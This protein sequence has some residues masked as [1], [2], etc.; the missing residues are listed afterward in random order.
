MPCARASQGRLSRATWSTVSGATTHEHPPLMKTLYGLSWRLFHR[1]DCTGPKRGLHP[2]AV[3]KHRTLP[4]FA[5]ESTA[6]RFPAI[7]LAGLGVALVYWF[8]R[9]WIGPWAAAGA[10]VL[11]VAQPHYFFHAQIFVFR[12]A[13]RGHGLAGGAGL[14]EIAARAPLGH[15]V[16][17][18]LWLG[19]GHQAQRLADSVFPAGPLPVDAKGGFLFMGTLKG[20]PDPSAPHLP[21][22]PA[23]LRSAS[24]DG[25]PPAKP[26][27][28]PRDSV[29]A[30]RAS[31]WA[32][33]S[34][35]T[36]G[37]I[38]LFVLW[39]WLWHAPVPRVREWM[40]RHAQHEHYNFEYLGR[41]WESAPAPSRPVAGC[42]ARPSVCIDGVHRAGHHLGPGC[43]WHAGVRPPTPKE[44]ARRP[45]S[46][47]QLRA[48]RAR[49]ARFLA[50]SR[51]RRG[52]RAR[53][54]SRGSDSGAA[55]NPWL[56]PRRRS[57]AG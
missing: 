11:S 48:A 42:C 51:R 20:F 52:P 33:V 6:F 49:G 1:C 41:N 28:S 16:R 53:N 32:F 36:L 30:R 47:H 54:L 39:P 18:L 34:M 9:R 2:I 38:V 15:S 10:A 44:G 25:A 24:R 13:H 14:L 7:L 26:A 56:F 19:P 45:T 31:R 27:G 46:H 50:A 22:L 37:P 3:H 4:L 57:S 21:P 35:A 17:R 23:R 8:A 43:G 12:C 40:Q 55:W 5:R 29:C